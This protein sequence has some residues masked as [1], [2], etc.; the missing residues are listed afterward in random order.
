MSFAP[1]GCG[2]GDVRFLRCR[3]HAVTIAHRTGVCQTPLTVLLPHRPSGFQR[4]LQFDR[5][6]IF[7][8]HSC[9]AVVGKPTAA[10]DAKRHG[11]R[12]RF[13]CTVVLFVSFKFS[14][15]S[16]HGCFQPYTFDAVKGYHNPCSHPI[17]YRKFGSQLSK[18][19]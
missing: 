11:K 18:S 1:P 15:Y 17:H 7:L 13:L 12:L 2:S 8:R 3:S 19:R 4:F 10:S 16:I 5:Q 9:R 6:V 14:G